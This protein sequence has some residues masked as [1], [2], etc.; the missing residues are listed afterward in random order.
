MLSA[1]L[2][3]II[4]TPFPFEVKR[5]FSVEPLVGYSLLDKNDDSALGAG[6]RVSYLFTSSTDAFVTIEAGSDWQ[7]ILKSDRETN[8]R[9][10][11][12]GMVMAYE[13]YN[14]WAMRV[15][16]G[17]GMER[18]LS[19]WNP[20]INYRLGVGRYLSSRIGI[21]GDLVGRFVKR[22]EWANPLEF[23]LSFQ[24]II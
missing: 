14:P 6:A 24:I 5:G 16:G 7:R 21:F 18:R 17:G 4:Q 11:F 12:E 13:I 19:Q 10:L 1:L 2:L 3:I 9:V 22:V 15:G 20:L 8:T 23:T